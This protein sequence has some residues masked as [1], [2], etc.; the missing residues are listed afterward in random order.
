AAE[1]AVAGHRRRHDG[2]RDIPAL[3]TRPA[4]HASVSAAVAASRAPLMKNLCELLAGRERA[5]FELHYSARTPATGKCP[6]SDA[7]RQS[8]PMH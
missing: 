8:N 3:L 5:P 2:R 6:E 1:E 4:A 7:P